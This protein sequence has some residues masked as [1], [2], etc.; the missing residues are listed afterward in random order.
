MSQRNQVRLTAVAAV[1]GLI[2]LSVVRARAET[3]SPLPLPNPYHV[4]ETFKLEMP[5]GLQSLGSVS[6]L[7]V[8]PDNNLYVFH[9]CVENTCTGHNDVPPILVY[10]QQGKLLKSMGVGM[11]VWPHGISVMP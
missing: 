9:R 8:G 4:D 6:G 5:P 3:A 1:L 10:N 7:K 11:V 2:T